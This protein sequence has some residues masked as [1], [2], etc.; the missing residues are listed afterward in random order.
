M[1]DITDNIILE[2]A[3][4]QMLRVP[5]NVESAEL[6]N[7]GGIKLSVPFAAY[8]A[9]GQCFIKDESVPAKLHSICLKAYGSDILRVTFDPAGVAEEDTPMLNPESMPAVMPL[10]VVTVEDGYEIYDSADNIRARI[11]CASIKTKHWSDLLPATEKMAEI[12]LLPDS[13]TSVPLK[14][15]DMFAHG[16]IESLPIGYIE[17]DGQIEKTLFSL[18]ADADECFYGTGERFAKM[19]LAGKTLKL[20]N[21]DGMGVNSRRCYK[22]IPFYISGRPYGLFVHTSSKIRLS[23]AD[24]STRAVQAQVSEAALDFFAIGGG[25]TKSILANYCSITGFAPELPL[26]SYG[27]WMSRMT[28]YTAEE[29]TRIADALRQQ[30]FPCDIMHIDTGWFPVDW[31]CDWKFC[32]KDFPEH[33]KFISDI[34]E[35]GFRIS[36]WQT[37]FRK[38]RKAA[39]PDPTFPGRIFWGRLIFPI[40]RLLNGIKMIYYDRCWKRECLLSK[41]TLAKILLW[42]R[43]IPG[44]RHPNSETDMLCFIRKQ[45]LKYQKKYM[46]KTM[47]LYGHEPAGPAVS[48]IRCTGAEMQNHPGTDWRQLYGADCTWGFQDL[49]TGHMMCPAFTVHLTL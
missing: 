45:P 40:R 18:N 22:N 12:E 6:L 29:V 25:N 28:Y 15:Y 23:L 16:R 20:E 42:M 3:A 21:D 33:Q 26:W 47:R 48:G 7:D 14:S 17:K 19:D 10:R 39:K 11:N 35:K 34:R 9:N 1:F 24:V 30:E 8:K 44:C 38:C 4:D 31:V 46:A 13:K 36:L 32:E 27:I 37:P 43:N 41:P 5:G 49:P 2:P